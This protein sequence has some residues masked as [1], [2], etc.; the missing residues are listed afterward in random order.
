MTLCEPHLSALVSR[1]SADGMH[2]TGEY[3]P[4]FLREF[5]LLVSI[6]VVA[7]ISA[8]TMVVVAGRR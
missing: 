3:T 6:I 2:H 8:H 7:M 5:L 1:G 4:T